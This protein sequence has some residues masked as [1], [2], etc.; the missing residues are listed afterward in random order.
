MNRRKFLGALPAALLLH[1]PLLQA[2]APPKGV[3]LMERVGP[4]SSELYA[5][6]A[7]G[8]GE[9]KLLESSNFEYHASFSPDSSRIIFTSERAGRG[10]A[11]IFTAGSDGN[12][13]KPLITEPAVD[14]AAVLSP[15]GTQLAF[16]S[17]RGTHRTNIWVMNLKTGAT[18]N[19]T[20][21]GDVQGDPSKP[22]GFFRPSWSPDG[23]WLAFS[24]DRNTEWKGHPCGPEIT[25][26]CAAGHGEG[27]EHVQQLSIYVIHLDGQGFRRIVSDPEK[28]MGS[29]KWSRDGKRIVFYE[30]PVIDSWNAR[31]QFLSKRATSQIVSVDVSTGERRTHT[32][33]PGLKLFP[34]FLGNDEIGYHVKAGE[35]EG[36]H[37]TSG[38][39]A[40]KA[41]LRSPSWSPDGTKV[42]YEKTGW[43]PLT[44]NTQLY[45]WDPQYDYR[46]TDSFPRLSSR[47][48]LVL[49]DRSEI[50]KIAVMNPDGSDRRNAFVSGGKGMA[51]EP[52]WSPDGEWIVFGYGEWFEQ[53]MTKPAKLM[54]VRADGTGLETLLEGAFNAGFPSYAPDGRHIV[55]RL[56][57]DDGAAGLRILD[58][59][60]RSVRTLTDAEDNLPDWSPD[61]QR[62][63]FTRKIA[64]GDFEVFTIRPD[65]SDTRR[66][67]FSAANDAHAVWTSDGRLLWNSGAYGFKDEAAAYD[68]NF[69]PYGQIW[70]MNADGSNKHA[71]TDSLWEDAQPL[72]IPSSAFSR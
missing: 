46:S 8:T 4:T 22:D 16:V 32:S 50:S 60:T 31:I 48:K 30:M 17:T 29:P 15:D 3:M 62:I 37:Y 38:K 54:R 21:G 70:I 56:W 63:A 68:R 40:V 23:K 26:S 67:T 9:R 13:I 10:Q 72:Y 36:L 7:D 61:G 45:S 24:S 20:G 35:V 12:D 69:Q 18:R 53:R 71:V 27:W 6:N 14:D 52:C 59:Q 44:Q 19:L 43:R 39:P 41:D 42:V 64:S 55:F 11:D 51:F 5:A 57:T 33:G 1:R 2:L 25:T 49:T 66:L 65:G 34:Q 58:Q 28:T 47:G